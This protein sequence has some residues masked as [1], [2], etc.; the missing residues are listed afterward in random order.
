MLCIFHL[1]VS[2]NR[3]ILIGILPL[4]QEILVSRFGLRKPSLHQVRAC[5]LQTRQR[6][7]RQIHYDTG[8][9]NDLLKFE[10]GFL[11][12]FCLQVSE[13]PD[14]CREQSCRKS[15][16]VRKSCFKNQQRAPRI[17]LF[18]TDRAAR[19]HPA[20]DRFFRLLS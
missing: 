8:M 10:P 18:Y 17:L 9:V 20:Y 6:A 3:R 1:G 7:N 19:T 12:I 16:F 2:Q 4:I 5:H 13:P 15:K 14:V 11:S